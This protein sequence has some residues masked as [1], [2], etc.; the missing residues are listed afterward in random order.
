MDQSYPSHFHLFWDDGKQKST[1][2]HMEMSKWANRKHP[3]AA[4]LRNSQSLGTEVPAYTNIQI[5]YQQF[6]KKAQ[7]RPWESILQ[8]AGLFY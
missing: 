3:Q 2:K 6:Y 7:S 4:H 8:E 5:N 1:I